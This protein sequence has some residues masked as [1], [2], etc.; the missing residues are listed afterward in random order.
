MPDQATAT[1]T[2][3]SP[4]AQST[5]IKAESNDACLITYAGSKEMGAKEL[6]A[7]IQE[8][9]KTSIILIDAPE[10]KKA[11]EANLK[12]LGDQI[13][14][15]FFHL[16]L[17]GIALPIILFLA[18]KPSNFSAWVA[19]N[20]KKPI[21]MSIALLLGTILTCLFGVALVA[22][23]AHYDVSN[24][25][26][27]GS[28][29]LIQ[30]IWGSAATITAAVVAI[31]LALEAIKTAETTNRLQQEA[32]QL[33]EYESPSFAL[34]QEVVGFKRRL[35]CHALFI[36]RLLSMSNGQVTEGSTLSL[37]E[38]SFRDVLSLYREIINSEVFILLSNQPLSHL[39]DSRP[40]EVII[41]EF[42]RIFNLENKFKEKVY[43]C[44]DLLVVLSVF[45][46]NVLNE[47]NDTKDARLKVKI[48]NEIGRAHWVYL[49]TLKLALNHLK[50]E[51]IDK[52]TSGKM[53][54]SKHILEPEVQNEKKTEV[55]SN[56]KEM[57]KP[58]EADDI[59]Y[60]LALLMKNKKQEPMQK[61]NS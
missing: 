29:S 18:K 14:P 6:A 50:Y 36:H 54:S 4:P 34:L 40:N 25:F 30:A 56:T 42:P 51:V 16:L 48:M 8:K 57:P 33:S 10:E 60:E 13:S 53:G 22:L 47:I 61:S 58:S 44:S 3:S 52:Y 23:Y 45:S 24:D 37:Y 9:C 31:M 28:G 35:D 5:N 19:S 7:K 46:V 49:Y 26:A 20:I 59:M 32:N 41:R 43:N 11:T 1:T 2:T 17:A 55:S 12:S 38:D 21:G 15:I 39:S 27:Q